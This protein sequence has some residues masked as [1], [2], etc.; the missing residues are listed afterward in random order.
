MYCRGVV[1]SV[2]YQATAERTVVCACVDRRSDSLSRRDLQC[3]YH[4]IVRHQHQ[5]PIEASISN[6][7]TCDGYPFLDIST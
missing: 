5:G 1:I 6:G 3:S 2:F 4:N 7:F